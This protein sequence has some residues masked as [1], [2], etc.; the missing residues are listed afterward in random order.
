MLDRAYEELLDLAIN[1]NS[2]V[3][4]DEFLRRVLD[5]Y[6]FESIAYAAFNVP[7]PDAHGPVYQNTY[8]DPWRVH[9]H[10]NQFIA[11]DPVVHFALSG[12]LPTDWQELRLRPGGRVLNEAGAFGIGQQGLTLPMRG[13]HGETA[14]FSISARLS[15]SK[16]RQLKKQY[17]RDLQS[18]A[19]YFHVSVL[20]RL[21]LDQPQIK[22]MSARELECLKWA[23][24]G[25]SASETAIIINITDRTV[26]FHLSSARYK[27][28][29]LTTTQAVAKALTTRQMTL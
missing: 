17:I 7:L 23:A 21:G 14:A 8:C 2:K 19:N 1:I 13:V 3:S 9:Y 4:G 5:T 15:D 16:W 27:L 11:I 28:N 10:R 24:L 25:K 29:C 12:M 22:L 6:G 26:A 20:H 18:L